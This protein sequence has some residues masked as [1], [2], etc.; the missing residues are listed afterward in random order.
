MFAHK[1]E[2]AHISKQMELVPFIIFLELPVIFFTTQGSSASLY[3][4]EKERGKD[5]CTT[6]PQTSPRRWKGGGQ[7]AQHY[8]TD[9]SPIIMTHKNDLCRGLTPDPA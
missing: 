8:I 1:K 9:R 3:Y 7:T 2:C 5:P 4:R 6:Q